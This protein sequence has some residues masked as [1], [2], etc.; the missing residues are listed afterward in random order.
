MAYKTRS[1][2]LKLQ[3]LI[4]VLKERGSETAVNLESSASDFLNDVKVNKFYNKGASI[5]HVSKILPIFDP[6]P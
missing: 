6:P 1:D 2:T 3:R 4:D 5:N